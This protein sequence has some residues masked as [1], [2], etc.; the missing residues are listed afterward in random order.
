[1]SIATTT[2]DVSVPVNGSHIARYL[3]SSWAWPEF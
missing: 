3:C 1:M 2:Y